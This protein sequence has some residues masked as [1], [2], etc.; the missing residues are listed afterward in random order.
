MYNID[1]GNL[2]ARTA[3][4]FGAASVVLLI[5]SYP[6]VPDL[7]GLSTTEI[8]WL[9]ENKIS[10]RR[11][12]EYAHGKAAEEVATAAAAKVSASKAQGV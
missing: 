1:S 4:V 12:Q 5:L 6:L 9:Y 7:R 11:F 10:P 2:G 3:L 8:D